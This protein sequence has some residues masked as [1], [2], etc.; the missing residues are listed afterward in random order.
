M[1]GPDYC[2]H[3]K[4]KNLIPPFSSIKNKKAGRDD[5][6]RSACQR[7][8]YVLYNYELHM[9]M[10]PVTIPYPLVPGLTEIETLEYSIP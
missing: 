4:I 8:D 5:F 10:S 2:H 9:A 7:L 1:A 6:P 3:L